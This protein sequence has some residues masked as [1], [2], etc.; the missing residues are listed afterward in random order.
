MTLYSLAIYNDNVLNDD[1]DSH[2]DNDSINNHTGDNDFKKIV[3]ASE[4]IYLIYRSIN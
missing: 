4:R 1:N 3:N 2:G